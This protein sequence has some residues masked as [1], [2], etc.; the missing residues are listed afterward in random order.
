MDISKEE[1]KNHF[2]TLLEGEVI[3]KDEEFRE[4]RDAHEEIIRIREDQ[5]RSQIEEEEIWNAVK[6]FKKKKAVGVDGIPMETWKSGGD[7][8]WDGLVELMR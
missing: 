6:K 2:M 8:V 5:T 3:G 4:N 1:W 7:A